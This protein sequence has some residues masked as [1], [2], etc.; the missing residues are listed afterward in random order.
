MTRTEQSRTADVQAP[1]MAIDGRVSNGARPPHHGT[2]SYI[3]VGNEVECFRNAYR[4]RLPI[5]LK[6][7]TGVGKTR[8]VETMAAE[9]GRELITVACHEDLTASDLV[10][11]FL[12]EGDA[13]VWADGPLTTAVRR[14]AICYL[15][16]VVEARQDTTVILHPLTDH[17]RSLPIERLG[18]TLQAPAEFCLVVSFNPGYQSLLKDMKDS[19]R[20]R[21]VGIE[22]GFPPPNVETRVLI[23]ETGIAVDDAERLV[24]IGQAMRRAQVGRREAASTRTLIAA[25]RLV[26]MGMN[27]VDAIRASLIVPL[28]DDPDEA[29]GLQELVD[30]YLGG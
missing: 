4:A 23:D 22:L 17:R 27:L 18:T 12:L 16:E 9:F 20:Q 1:S 5:L 3:P 25:A 10:G 14:G 8:L 6:G 15:D 7:P 2:P 26:A 28:T 29:A 11:R 24:A 13:T 19:T 30:T 21:F